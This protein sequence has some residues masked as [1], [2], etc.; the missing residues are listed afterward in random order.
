MTDINLTAA[1]DA[2]EQACVQYGVYRYLEDPD[3]S[4]LSMDQV[5]MID[6]AVKAAAPLIVA[7]ALREAALILTGAVSIRQ[8]RAMI[9][10]RAD[11]M[12]AR[13]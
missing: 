10:A 7:Q 2:A 12:E 5:D 13:P 3:Q 11:E 8:G 6:D 1:F 4:P 9:L